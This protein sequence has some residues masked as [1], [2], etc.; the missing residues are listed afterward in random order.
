[1]NVNTL[2]NQIKNKTDWTEAACNSE[3]WTAWHEF[4]LEIIMNTKCK[5][6]VFSVL[7][8]GPQIAN[9]IECGNRF[10]NHLTISF[11]PSIS[12]SMQ[13]W[14]YIVGWIGETFAIAHFIQ[15]DW[16]KSSFYFGDWGQAPLSRSTPF[17]WF[18]EFAG[19]RHRNHVVWRLIDDF[20][21]HLQIHTS[22]YTRTHTHTRSHLVYHL[23]AKGAQS[24]KKCYHESTN[25]HWPNR[26]AVG[27]SYEI[28]VQFYSLLYCFLFSFFAASCASSSHSNELYCRNSENDSYGKRTFRRKC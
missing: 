2:K 7:K 21:E 18:N 24:I 27:Y 6:G 5:H 8:V 11:L 25:V 4:Y 10:V 23:N 3:H 17:W 20:C 12:L 28:F 19:K 14:M 16:I 13:K 9:D 1:M 22:A 15:D 26:C